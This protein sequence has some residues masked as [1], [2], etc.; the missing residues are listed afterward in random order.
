MALLAELASVEQQLAAAAKGGD[1]AS[2]LLRLRVVLRRCLL[3]LFLYA[4]D[5]PVHPSFLR[6]RLASAVAALARVAPN[7]DASSCP[8]WTLEVCCTIALVFCC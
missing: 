4:A 8:S 7:L 6:D 5:H 3:D 2:G 1:E